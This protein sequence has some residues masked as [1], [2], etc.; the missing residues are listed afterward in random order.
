MEI[1]ELDA[2]IQLWQLGDPTHTAP[3]VYIPDRVYVRRS[4]NQKLGEGSVKVERLHR[5]AVNQTDSTFDCCFL[6]FSKP[7]KMFA[8]R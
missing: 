4:S 1:A 3:F 5:S 2:S 8:D 7:L 6:A